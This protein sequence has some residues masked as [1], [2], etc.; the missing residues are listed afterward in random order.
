MPWNYQGTFKSAL[1]KRHHA[2][3]PIFV[4]CGAAKC[5]E[6]GAGIKQASVE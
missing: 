2:L 5:K 3:F 1:R 6:Q 4:F